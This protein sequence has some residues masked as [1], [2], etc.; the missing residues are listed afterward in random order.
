MEEEDEIEDNYD[1]YYD[2]V[3]RLAKK[4][5]KLEEEGL[6]EIAKKYKTDVSE[7]TELYAECQ[8]REWR[9]Q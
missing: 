7:I 6:E 2:E 8:Q 3:E 9:D 4:I 5:Y 1:Q